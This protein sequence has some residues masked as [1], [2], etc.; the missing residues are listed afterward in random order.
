M[1]YQGMFFFDFQDS[2]NFYV[3][4]LFLVNYNELVYHDFVKTKKVHCICGGKKSC[5]YIIKIIII[6]WKSLMNMINSLSLTKKQFETIY[7]LCIMNGFN[8]DRLLCRTMEKGSWGE[9][10]GGGS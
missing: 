10:G 4:F 8:A 7:Q 2:T 9:G 3:S 6:M 1:H 5:A